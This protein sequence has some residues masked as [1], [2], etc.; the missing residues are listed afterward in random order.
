MSISSAWVRGVVLVVLLAFGGCD[1]R[2]PGTPRNPANALYV[3]NQPD[4]TISIINP[5]TR[6]VATTVDLTEYGF[7]ANAK[8]HHV[9]V[10]PDGSAWYVS[11]IGDNTVA[12][13]NAKNELVGRIEF[14]SPGMLSLH[15]TEDLLY[16]G[17]TLSLPNV[18]NTVAV[19]DRA[20]MT[21]VEV[22][23]A[24]PIDRPHGIKVS[25]T[26]NYAYTTSLTANEIVAIDT[27]TQQVQSPVSLPG[28]PQFYVQLDITADGQTAYITGD[29]GNQVQ[30]LDLQNPIQ[31]TLE[32]RVTVDGRP[33]HPQLSDDGS[34]LY[35]GSK[36]TD[37][38][39]ALNAS[40][41]AP[42]TLE[43]KGLANPHGSALSPDGQFLYISNANPNGSYESSSGETVGTVVVINTRTFEIEDVIEVGNEPAGINTRWQ[44]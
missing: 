3:C 37:T 7:S 5:S 20:S 13:F 9:V 22:P 17:H 44:P 39:T 1:G 10:E 23:L 31:P 29:Q 28:P 34:T 40:S 15:P 8:P 25:P 2:G 43:G 35:F 19:I 32:A 11:L 30:V 38:V 12:K 41:L 6:T 27:E 18:P 14:E 21:P 26:G 33:W 42:E 36:A 16:A 4:A 24:V